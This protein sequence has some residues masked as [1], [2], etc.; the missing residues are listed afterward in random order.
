VTVPLAYEDQVSNPFLHSYHPDPDNLDAEFNATLPSGRES[1]SVTRR[2]TLKFTNPEDN[3]NGLTQGSQ[4]PHRSGRESEEPRVTGYRGANRLDGVS[5]ELRDDLP[6]RNQALQRAIEEAKS[7]AGAM[8]PALDVKLGKLREVIEGGIAVEPPRPLFAR[9][10][11]STFGAAETPVQPGELRVEASVTLRYDF[12]FTGLSAA[13]NSSRIVM[14]YCP[15]CK[16]G[17]GD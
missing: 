1:Y 6:Q 13:R 14:V 7:K 16:R 12:S 17:S 8:V 3:F 9:A 2:I 11:R 4:D 5:F 10:A 15:G